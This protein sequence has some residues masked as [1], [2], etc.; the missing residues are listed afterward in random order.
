VPIV[1]LSRPTTQKP[2]RTAKF[3]GAFVS[4]Y[5]VKWLVM[6]GAKDSPGVARTLD[7]LHQYPFFTPPANAGYALFV[8]VDR[9]GAVLDIYDTLP[10]TI[11][12]S[13]VIETPN[14]A[15]VGWF[16][17][18]VDLRENARSHPIRYARNIG[19]A[20]AKALNGD[21]LVDPLSPSRVRNPAYEY[22]DTFSPATPKIYHLGELYQALKAAGLWT[23]KSRKFSNRK[24]V[25]QPTTGS[26]PVGN[27]NKG[28]FDAA[29]FVAYA[30][31]DYVA[32]AWAANDRCE[33]PLKANEVHHII[34]SIARY[35]ATKGHT[36]TNGPT[37]AM[38][39]PMRS[40]LSD[41]GR[42]G[43]LANTPAQRAARAKGPAAAAAARKHRAYQ[44]AKQAQHLRRRGYNRKQIA[45][46]LGRDPSTV[47]RYLRRWI[48]IPLREMLACITGASGD[49][50]SAPPTRHP[51][52]PGPP[53][54]PGVPPQHQSA[55]KS[56]SSRATNCHLAPVRNTL[57]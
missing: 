23:Y 6:A 21:P 15:Q 17:D 55:P 25:V 11:A 30:G 46:Q 20:L 56:N 39:E 53:L 31:G 51:L 19:K 41:M 14:G 4:H 12:P 34:N 45:A 5:T 13:W 2:S 8:D 26:I 29:R 54:P 52:S 48:P 57:R 47:S 27:R 22:A 44:K 42:R 35:M 32:E 50:T 28:I 43:G 9:P 40:V 16:I 7:H 36:R 10:T 24:P 37:K 38:P 1:A 18:P 49:A 33:A 3:R